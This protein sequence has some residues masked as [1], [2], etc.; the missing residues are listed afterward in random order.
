MLPTEA[1]HPRKQPLS[2]WGQAGGGGGWANSVESGRLRGPQLGKQRAQGSGT[3]VCGSQALRV[4]VADPTSAQQTHSPST[5]CPG[6]ETWV[7]AVGR[8]EA[9]V[10]AQP[11]PHNLQ[12]PLGP[13]HTET[14]WQTWGKQ[15]G[16]CG[17]DALV[18]GPGPRDRSEAS[19]T[20]EMPRLQD[21]LCGLQGGG[22]G[23]WLL[24]SPF[25]T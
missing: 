3:G 11:L 14:G 16:R 2:S 5:W 13:V 20:K 4:W 7:Q 18:P 10:P 6:Q 19:V 22:W 24:G 21:V 25:V 23:H 17:E 15:A 8:G 9:G 12:Q 1:S